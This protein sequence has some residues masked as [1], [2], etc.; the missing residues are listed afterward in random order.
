MSTYEKLEEAKRAVAEVK[1][2]HVPEIYKRTERINKDIE[3]GKWMAAER[4][5]LGMSQAQLGREIH[6]SH[7]VISWMETGQRHVTDEELEHLRKYVF[8][9]ANRKKYF[10][11]GPLADLVRQMDETWTSLKWEEGDSCDYVVML[12]ETD[13]TLDHE[14]KEIN[15]DA[16]VDDIAARI[17]NSVHECKIWSR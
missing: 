5:K 16:H 8:T 1:Y 14:V 15:K 9:E 10:V 6:Y 2:H 3:V 12:S 7:T 4:Q 17:V 11:E 13:G